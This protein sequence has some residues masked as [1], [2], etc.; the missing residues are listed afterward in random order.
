VTTTLGHFV[1]YPTKPTKG[2][3]KFLKFG[4][5]TL[6]DEF[7]P[8]NYDVL[9]PTALGVPANKNGE[10][11]ADA[12][13]HLEAYA[14]KPAKGSA[15]FAPRLDVHVANQCSDL[16]VTASKP[17]SVLVPTAE[18]PNAAVP[19][20]DENLHNVDHFLCYRAKTQK[21]RAN[22]TLVA[23]FP[24]GVQADVV[25]EFA[26]RRY[27]LAGIALL[28][29]PVAKSGTPIVLAGPTKGAAVPITPAA[30]R[31]PESHLV[32]YT[33]KIAKKHIDQRGCGAANPADK[34]T[35]ITPTQARPVAEVA[36][37]V[38]NQFG[39]GEVDAKK[40]TLLCIPTALVP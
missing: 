32:C 15:K 26:T 13:T 7:G 21:K 16:F 5:V 11:I 31:N 28:C 34:G 24:K 23:T 38:A 25:D 29:N 2:V 39:S 1:S 35:P 6:T 10:G 20:P 17:V 30:I 33:A 12:T 9:K 37:H 3:A 22:G 18:D 14:L 4:A 36:L 27:D 8:G 40:P 19:P